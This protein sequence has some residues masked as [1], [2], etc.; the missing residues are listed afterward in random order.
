MQCVSVLVRRSVYEQLGGY[1]SDLIYALDWEM[2]VRI[3]VR[4]AVWYEPRMLAFYRRHGDSETARLAKAGMLLRDMLEAI[5]SFSG[6][7]PERERA[8]MCSKAYAFF[9]RRTLKE[10]TA[11]APKTD[12]ELIEVLEIVSGAAQRITHSARIRRLLQERI[13]SLEKDRASD[14]A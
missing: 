7:L 8:I 3:A 11:R 10:M 9:A 12:Q 1:R 5:E 6:L 14:V 13:V 2:W 4:F